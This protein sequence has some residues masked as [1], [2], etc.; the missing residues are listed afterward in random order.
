MGA[1]WRSLWTLVVW[2]LL[3]FTSCMVGPAVAHGGNGDRHDEESVNSKDR[4]LLLVKICCLFILIVAT[5]FPGISPYFF[6]WNPAFLVLGIQF[7]GGVFLSTALLHFLGDAN[8]AF[9]ERTANQYPFAFMLAC[10][11]YLITNA[12]DLVA[13][14]VAAR[15]TVSDCRPDVEC[16]SGGKPCKPADGT[17]NSCCGTDDAEDDCKCPDDVPVEQRR[18]AL[19]ELCDSDAAQGIRSERIIPDKSFSSCAAFSFAFSISSPVGIGIGIIISQTT[20]GSIADW[21]YA[22]SMSFAAGVFIYV[23]VNHLLAKGYTPPCKVGVDRPSW[24]LLFVTIGVAVMGV[25][26]ISD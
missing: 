1:V 15:Q 25:V 16:S 20:Q 5:F 8:E 14:H 17:A 19:G 7:A 9:K 12:A 23:A 21:V 13:Q 22:I 3:F 4:D 6:R 24:K 18:P 26:M 11:G 2:S 10:I